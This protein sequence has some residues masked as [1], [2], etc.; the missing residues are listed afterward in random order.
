MSAH[1]CTMEDRVEH[2]EKTV[3]DHEVRLRGSEKSLSE[4]DT[5]FT[6]LEGKLESVSESLKELSESIRGAVRWVLGIAGTAAAS[7]V[8]WA[9]AQSQR[10]AP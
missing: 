5:R 10:G 4:G 1:V 2:V 6:R 8:L 9:F 3:A 7:A